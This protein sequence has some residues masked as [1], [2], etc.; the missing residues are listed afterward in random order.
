MTGARVNGRVGVLIAEPHEVCR[1]AV[2][3]MIT[4]AADGL[5]V[6]GE[7]GARA[8]AVPLAERTSPGVV[9]LG[10]AGPQEYDV[11]GELLGRAPG[12]RIVVLALAR[13]DEAVLDAVLA[14]AVG[15][16]PESAE[17]AEVLDALVRVARGEV[18]LHPSVAAAGLVC[19]ARRLREVVE[20]QGPLGELTQREREVLGLLCEGVTPK[21]IAARLYVSRRT[22]ES[23]LS[24]AYRKLGVRGR[25]EAMSKV[26]ELQG[27][28]GG[29]TP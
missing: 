22:V 18:V 27:G 2:A 20:G 21:A 25:M 28:G 9:L 5:H 12:V 14:G 17:P 10:L 19:A 3:G 6:V 7:T 26:R 15:F 13:E 29:T 11:I 4:G 8:E 16:V 24:S 1:R 23:H